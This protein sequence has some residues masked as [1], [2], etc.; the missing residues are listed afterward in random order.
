MVASYRFPIPI[1]QHSFSRSTDREH[2]RPRAYVP[3]SRCSTVLICNCIPSDG[4]IVGI[5]RT[6]RHRHVRIDIADRTVRVGGRTSRV[7]LLVAEDWYFT[8]GRDCAGSS[9]RLTF[10]GSSFGRRATFHESSVNQGTPPERGQRS[11]SFPV[12]ER[13]REERNSV[14]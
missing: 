13:R 8:E 11:S 7:N 10:S 9:C 2:V 1:M 4:V 3:L 14:R 5:G 12:R 6:S